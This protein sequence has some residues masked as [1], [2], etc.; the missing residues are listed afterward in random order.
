[1]GLLHHPRL[2]FSLFWHFWASHLNFLTTLFG[3]RSLMRSQYPKMRICVTLL[4]YNQIKGCT[5]LSRSLFIYW[6]KEK[7]CR[8]ADE[9]S[10]T[11]TS[12]W[13]KLLAQFYF[14]TVYLRKQL[15]SRIETMSIV[16][17]SIF[18]LR[19]IVLNDARPYHTVRTTK[20]R[21]KRVHGCQVCNSIGVYCSL[22]A[23]C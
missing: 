16:L 14:K 18:L 4:Q 20:M 10:V 1:M 11:K 8:I 6:Y 2:A 3:L 19:I 13:L 21:A 12:L 7:S 9:G 22:F 5:H 15:R 23:Y 17:L